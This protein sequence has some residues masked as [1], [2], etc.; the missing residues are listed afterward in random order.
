MG[1]A[2]SPNLEL[3]PTETQLMIWSN[4]DRQGRQNLILISDAYSGFHNH[5][6]DLERSIESTM[7]S[8]YACFSC[9][10]MLPKWKFADSAITGP[11]RRNGPNM[12]LRFCIKCGILARQ[13]TLH[14]AKGQVFFIRQRNFVLCWRCE[15]LGQTRKSGGTKAVCVNC[16]EGREPNSFQDRLEEAWAVAQSA[17]EGIAGGRHARQ[18]QG[19]RPGGWRGGGAQDYF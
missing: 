18:D 2:T 4:F 13:D 19:G 9:L 10:S 14:Y 3:I 6:V 15:R 7:E 11:K 8:T 17:E 16:E 5:L 1:S 12:D